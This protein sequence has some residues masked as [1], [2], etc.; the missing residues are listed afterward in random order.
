[1]ESP[2]GKTPRTGANHVMVPERSDSGERTKIHTG[3]ELAGR[4]QLE[5]EDAQDKR[6]GGHV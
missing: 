2:R 5:K 6:S 4:M 1:M 3:F